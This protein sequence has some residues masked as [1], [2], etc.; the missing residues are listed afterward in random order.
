MNFIVK[1]FSISILFILLQG[2][3]YFNTTTITKKQIKELS[4]WNDKDQ[5][6]S[7]VDCEGLEGDENMDC[8]KNIITESLSDVL[9]EYSFNS[10]NLLNEEIIVTLE[11]DIDGNFSLLNI[12]DDA[13]VLSQIDSLSEILET[14]V[15]SLPQALPA[16]K[17]NVG[18]KV[19]TQLKLPV[20]IIASPQ[21]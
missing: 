2:C 16:V 18:S 9:A 13:D 5:A 20:R 8:F 14:A 21:E 15:T 19:K 17:T 3:E 1:T 12:E 4:K 7:F 10:V 6:P 11:I